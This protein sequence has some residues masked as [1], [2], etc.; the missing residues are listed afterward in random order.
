MGL[1]YIPSPAS[2]AP[3]RTALAKNEC[4]LIAW[5]NTRTGTLYIKA[6]LSHAEYDK[7]CKSDVR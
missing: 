7:W 1:L 5:L 4:R 3:T 2:P 6:I